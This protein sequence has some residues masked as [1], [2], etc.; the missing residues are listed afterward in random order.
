MQIPIPDNRLMN[1]MRRGHRARLGHDLTGYLTESGTPG[2]TRIVRT[3]CDDD[4]VPWS[5]RCTAED[6]CPV[7]AAQGGLS[8]NH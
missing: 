1:A 3:C 8:C 7:R 5:D 2:V 6:P 4:G